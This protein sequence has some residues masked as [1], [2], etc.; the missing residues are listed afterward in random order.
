MKTVHDIFAEA[1]ALQRQGLT[2]RQVADRIHEMGRD[3]GFAKIDEYGSVS[4]GTIELVFPVEAT[5]YFD[6]TE[7]HYLRRNSWPGRSPV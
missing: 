3:N 1:L 5:I 6:G 4:R 7:W 2:P